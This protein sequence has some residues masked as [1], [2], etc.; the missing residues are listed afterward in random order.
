M[1]ARKLFSLEL[2]GDPNDLAQQEDIKFKIKN[3]TAAT[4]LAP[5]KPPSVPK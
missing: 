2:N 5:P 3:L 4:P 1:A